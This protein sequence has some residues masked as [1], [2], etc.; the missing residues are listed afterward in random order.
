MERIKKEHNV[1]AMSPKNEPVLRVASGSTVVF[2]TYDCFTN[3]IKNQTD[4]FG[5]IGW[6]SI[7]PATGPLFI[8]DAEPND[9]LR[10][11]VLDISV[12]DQG[13][14]VTV[15]GLGVLGDQIQEE[16]TKIVPIQNGEAVF[17]DRI[18]IPIRPMI[19]VLGVAPAEE[20]ILTGT[21]GDH[22][23][24]MDCNRLVQGA[25][26]FLPVHVPGALLAMG[27]LHAIQGD[28]EVIVCGVEIPGEVTVKVTVIK[29]R[30]FPVPLLEEGDAIMTIASDK[31]L[32]DATKTA[33]KRMHAFLTDEL[34]IE[35]H[36]AGMLL[37]ILGQLR[38]CQVVDPLMTAR[39]ELPKWVLAKYD[40]R[41]PVS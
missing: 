13:V 34:Q 2:E 35:F 14:M 21:P 29:G 8:D 1:L 6:D 3:K 28:G 17:N 38:I 18:L 20:E 30:S 11:D 31:L 32:D 16:R 25:T 9:I 15:P 39:M 36:E 26:L 27:D 10:I 33:T 19:G 23:A 37:S 41:L 40:Y 22:G 12:V 7:N 4:L 24:N 5:S